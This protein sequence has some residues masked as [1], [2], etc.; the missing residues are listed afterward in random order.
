MMELMDPIVLAFW[1]QDDGSM[2]VATHSYTKRDVKRLSR[3]LFIKYGQICTAYD[4]ERKK[5]GFYYVLSIKPQ[6][7]D[8][9]RSLVLP[10]FHQTMRYKQGQLNVPKLNPIGLSQLG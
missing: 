7:M 9:L 2:E 10:Y 6:S 3:I 1:L 4:V 8:K 5:G